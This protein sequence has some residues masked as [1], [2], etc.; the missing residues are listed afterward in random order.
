MIKLKDKIVRICE[1]KIVY[2]SHVH[3][4]CNSKLLDPSLI[5]FYTQ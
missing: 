5:S 3:D 4:F 1:L 2:G